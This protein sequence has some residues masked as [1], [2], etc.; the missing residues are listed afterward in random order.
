MDV[1]LTAIIGAFSTLVG[2]FV[3]W[4]FARKKYNS[5][6][7]GNIIKNMQESFD[8]YNK[9]IESHK[10][11]L[12]SNQENIEKCN[13]TNKQILE[14]NESIKKENMQLLKDLSYFKT[15]VIS[16]LN[17]ICLNM[18]CSERILDSN[19]INDMKSKIVDFDKKSKSKNK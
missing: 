19:I 12:E 13:I 8:F 16:L 17:N 9:V 11:I 2:S 6:V 7:D 5:E 18:A 4:I 14:E 1:I 3:S 15:Q 10:Q